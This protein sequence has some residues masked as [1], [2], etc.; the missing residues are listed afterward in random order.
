MDKVDFKKKYKSVYAPSSKTP[1]IITMPK[2][3]YIVL[4]GIGNPNTSQSFSDAIGALY[5]LAYT[6]SMSYK[7]DALVIPNFYNFTVPPL[8]GV[9]DIADGTK[10]D[11]NNKDNLKWTIGILMPEFVN[12]EVLTKAIDIAYNK[13]K[14]ELIKDITLKVYEDKEC[15]TMMHL[16][17]Y[18]DEPATF[19]KMMEYAESQGYKRTEKTHRE[20][21]L[22]DFRKVVPEKLKTVLRFKVD[23][24]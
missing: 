1:S 17:P 11:K 8:E 5:G 9:W 16:G 10:Y 3:Q 14:N 7:G 22:S 2:M 24:Q 6:I 15:C 13:K 23:K 4:S 21:Y 12:E 18:D 20:I 19:D